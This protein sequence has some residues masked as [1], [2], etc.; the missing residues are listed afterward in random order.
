LMNGNGSNGPILNITG[1]RVALGPLR[2]DLM[3]T[4]Q[5]WLNDF[6]TDRTQG[7]LPGPRT[8]QR[9]HAWYERVSSSTESMW[10]LIYERATGQPIGF[11]WLD[12]IDF[13]HRIGSFAISIGEESMRGKGY[14]TE[15]TRLMLDFAF[16]ALGLHNV[17]LEVYSHNLAGI[18]AYERAGFR[19]YGRRHECFSMGAQLWDEVL[20]E[21]LSSNFDSPV[22]SAI[23]VPDLER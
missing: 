7:D 12:S 3:D 19:E 10:H 6:G 2:D 1:E 13:R 18:R 16:T 9:V 11:T 5:R 14:G 22:L 8:E 20:M 23:F 21:C 17:S 15:T 4:Y